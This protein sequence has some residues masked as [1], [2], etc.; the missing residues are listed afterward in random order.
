MKFFITFLLLVLTV[1]VF[2]HDHHDHGRRGHDRRRQGDVEINIFDISNTLIFSSWT[3]DEKE[4][5]AQ[6]INDTQ[7]FVQSGT[8][9]VFLSQK[10]SEIQSTDQDLSVED[11]L[12]LI[13]PA[14]KTK[15]E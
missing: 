3:M 7:A 2:A 8:M 4:E 12:D 9:S 13:V 1:Q 10:I 14:A 11:V 15:L 5:A 6:I